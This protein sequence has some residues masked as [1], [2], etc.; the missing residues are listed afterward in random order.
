MEL[1]GRFI[2][3]LGLLLA[4]LRLQDHPEGVEAVDVGGVQRQG[5][6][7][8]RLSLRELPD[9]VVE[10]CEGEEGLR[11]PGHVLDALEELSAGALDEAVEGVVD[12]LDLCLVVPGVLQGVVPG[13]LSR[14]WRPQRDR[15]KA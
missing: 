5:L 8:P 9:R 12:H 11:H 14:E 1:H 3:V 7:V 2:D 10:V 4:L 6:A 13:H 15:Q